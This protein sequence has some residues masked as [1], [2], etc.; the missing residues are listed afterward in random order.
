[1][2]SVCLVVFVFFFQAEDGIRDDLVTGV[3]TCAL[4]ISSKKELLEQITDLEPSPLRQMDERIPKELERICF[5]ALSK[6]AAERYLTAKDMVEELRHF[7]S[8]QTV[9]QQAVPVGKGVPSPFATTVATPTSDIQPV[10][11]VPKGLRSF[12]AHDAG[13]F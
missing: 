3:Q 6:R 10:K 4:P 5:K 13:F 2:C 1:M 11:I 9:S 7:V 12:D 8:E